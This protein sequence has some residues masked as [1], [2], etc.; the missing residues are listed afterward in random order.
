M[1]LCS[2]HYLSGVIWV[3]D[4]RIAV[5]WE[6]RSQNHVTLQLYDFNG[7]AWV[8]KVVHVIAKCKLTR[9]PF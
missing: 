6:M 1:S 4:E 3:T 5:Q 2:E 7:T 9:D 8:E